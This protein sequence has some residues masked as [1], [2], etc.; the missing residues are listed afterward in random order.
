MLEKEIAPTILDSMD[1]LYNEREAYI[2]KLQNM[3]GDAKTELEELRKAY[4]E[5]LVELK[6]QGII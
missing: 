3:Y 1:K 2:L 4:C 5:L 6:L